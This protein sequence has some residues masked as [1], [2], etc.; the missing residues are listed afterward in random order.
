[1]DERIFKTLSNASQDVMMDRVESIAI[2]YITKDGNMET[3][4]DKNDEASAIELLGG[5]E[6]LKNRVMNG[7]FEFPEFRDDEDME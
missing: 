6:F 1:M 3:A 4:Y 5:L 2:I 7:Y